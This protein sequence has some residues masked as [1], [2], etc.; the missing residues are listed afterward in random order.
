MSVMVPSGCIVLGQ[1][2]GIWF[3]HAAM[4]SHL[5]IFDKTIEIIFLESLRRGEINFRAD[6]IAKERG[7][8]LC[9]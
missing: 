8:V 7:S 3:L 4:V 5:W 6:G 9:S 1:F 2:G